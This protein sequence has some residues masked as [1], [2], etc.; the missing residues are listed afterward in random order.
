MV[1]C[2]GIMDVTSYLKYAGSVA[3]TA[4]L[5]NAGFSDGHIRVAVGSGQIRRLRHGVV[6]LPGA[7]PDLVSA[8]LA[9]GLLSCGSAT[10]H[11][12]LW[13]LHEPAALHLLC[14]HGAAKDVVVHRETVVPQDVP[15][16]VAG[17]TDVLLHG[18]LQGRTT[19]AY[20][21]GHL[22]GNRNGAARRVL[23]LVDG[24]A[25]SP[26]EVVARLLFRSE[27]IFVQTQVDLP[28]IGI[29]DFLLEGF[30]IVELDGETHL[31]PR[32]VKKDRLRNNASTLDGYAV[33]RYG[34][35][36]VVYNPQKIVDEVWQ[37][38]RGRV[39]R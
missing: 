13:R 27:G 1:G 21:R 6:A 3:R 25:G 4:T 33:L 10:T 20:L 18:L 17:L 8:V 12:R 30:L 23:D 11:H 22:P 29:V 32:Q 5:R 34:Y 36:Q 24:T 35:A 9:N 37:V 16:P 19:L 31:Q 2:A 14:R 15:W 28:G 7:A 39:V 38:L 26:I